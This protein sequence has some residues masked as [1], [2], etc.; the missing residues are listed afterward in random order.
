[1]GLLI[2]GA[3]GYT[4]RIMIEDAASFGLTPILGGRSAAV[5][6]LAEHK[7]LEYRIFNLG[8]RDETARALEGVKV[9]LHCAGPFR[10]TAQQMM[11][12]CLITGT[13]YLDITGEISVFEL[14]AAYN[15]KAL[16]K[17]IMIMPGVGFDVVP[18]DCLAAFLKEQLPAASS[19]K[20][21]FAGLGGSMSKG[22]TLTMIEGMGEGSKVRKNGVIESVPLGFKTMERSY[23]GKNLFFMTIPWGDVS[24]AFYTT[25]IPNIETY[26]TVSKKRYRKLGWMNALAWLLKLDFIKEFA[27]KKVRQGPA[28]PSEEIRKHSRT[29]LWGEVTDKEGKKVEAWYTTPNGYTVTSHTGLLIAKKV[30]EGSF[31][32]GFQTPA[33]LYGQDL[34][35]ELSDITPFT[36]IS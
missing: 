3:N 19:L 33:G 31:K 15:Q 11:E 12:A 30:L 32:I 1:M 35:Q 13:H 29:Y 5:K 28:G 9:V 6:E 23:N 20:L 24:T 4:G 22:T 14:G 7:G 17:G 18:T 34:I 26:T 25:G 2:Y 36:I 16:D 10:F 27:R 21:A 8:N